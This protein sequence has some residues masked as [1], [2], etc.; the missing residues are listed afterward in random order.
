[1]WSGNRGLC[2]DERENLKFPTSELYDKQV[3]NS[4]DTVQTTIV[5]LLLESYQIH[6]RKQR[7]IDGSLPRILLNNDTR[8]I[9]YSAAVTEATSEKE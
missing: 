7:N 3:L 5:D 9:S 6:Q 2:Q 8:K 4:K 1:M